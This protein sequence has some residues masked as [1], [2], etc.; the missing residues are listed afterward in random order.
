MTPTIAAP[1]NGRHHHHHD[2]HVPDPHGE[3]PGYIALQL[4]GLSK[5]VMA[6]AT[7]DTDDLDAQAAFFIGTTGGDGGAYL[8]DIVIADGRRLKAD[9]YA[10]EPVSDVAVL[11]ALDDQV[12]PEEAE[13][14]EDF[15]AATVPVDLAVAEFRLRKAFDV[16]VFTHDKG[17][18]AA[19]AQQ[20]APMAMVLYIDA[21][22]SIE[23]GTS[24]GPVV[25]AD[26]RLVG[27]VSNAGGP[28]GGETR[29]GTI[30]R[31]HLAA[32]YRLVRQ[33]VPR[34]IARRLD[35]VLPPARDEIR[36]DRR[37]RRMVMKA[38][39]PR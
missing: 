32:P 19:R 24:G 18:V 28:V 27:I 23:G 2:R 5:L 13:A 29:D 16:F 31:L 3:D 12:H 22:A 11:G 4:L 7:S 9:P 25:L 39:A 1:S 33:M 38:M 36:V 6:S 26:G 14:F 37:R 8:E 17:V 20:G 21:G 15:C 30:T 34:R 10:V 35:A